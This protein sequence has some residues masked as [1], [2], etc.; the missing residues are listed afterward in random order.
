MTFELPKIKNIPP[1]PPCKPPKKE[2]GID[3]VLPMRDL[4]KLI[5]DKIFNDEGTKAGYVS[6]V[7]MFLC[8]NLKDDRLEDQKFREKQAVR[9][10]ERIFKG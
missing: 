3:Q 6:N 4:R 5:A 2:S 9:L 7:A 1:M 10:L 8:D